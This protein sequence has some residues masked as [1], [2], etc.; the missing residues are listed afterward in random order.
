MEDPDIVLDLRSLQSGQ[1]S[2]YDC[3]WDEVEKFLQEDVGLAVEERR[4]SDIASYFSQRSAAAS[5]CPP[6]TPI[7][8]RSW[9]SL[10]F[11]PKNRHWHSSC[12]YTSKLNVKYMV[13]TGQLRKSHEDSHYAAALSISARNGS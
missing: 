12:H 2:K 13:Q 8:S 6:S 3:F 10:Q 9:L 4:H 5:S 11:W 7:P 1:K